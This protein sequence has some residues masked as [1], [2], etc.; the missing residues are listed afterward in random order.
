[1]EAGLCLPARSGRSSCRACLTVCPAEAVTLSRG[2][3]VDPDAC[4]A[5]GLC[6]AACP[7]GALR[8]ETPSETA[9]LA[10]ARRAEGGP[11]VLA[12][13]AQAGSL[14]AGVR[15]RLV[16]VPCVGGLT[17][18]VLAGML[19]SSGT[20]RLVLWQPPACGPCPYGQSSLPLVRAA[21]AAVERLY[22]GSLAAVGEESLLAHGGD[23][24]VTPPA[25]TPL[26][27]RMAA[28][29]RRAFLGSAVRNS[30]SL[31]SLL[32][33]DWAGKPKRSAKV[34]R[35][36]AQS[37]PRRRQVLLEAVTVRPPAPGALLPEPAVQVTPACTLCPACSK[38]CPS[39]ALQLQVKDG[40]AELSWQVAQ[41]TG[42]G[43]CRESCPAGAMQTGPVL[44]VERFRAQEP[45]VVL[46]G[47]KAACACGM[48]F[49]QVPGGPV[50][51]VACRLRTA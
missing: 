22:P 8:M 41:C 10:A 12:C 42:C 23:P 34:E 50:R 40:R 11:V 15:D 1:V 2:P 24:V 31:L 32:L 17:M 46:A 29:D 51:C 27:Q 38:L 33:G 6:A 49:W 30:G 3:V 19:S 25:E 37:T 7:S 36:A 20:D 47:E 43:L 4:T 13:S 48:P 28:Q 14:P 18:E 9:L 26:D 5:C 16:L 21:V 44:T 45:D 39:G 35:H